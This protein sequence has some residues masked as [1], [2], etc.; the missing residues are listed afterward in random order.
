[1]ELADEA[2]AAAEHSVVCVRACCRIRKF[3]NSDSGFRTSE[4][5]VRVRSADRRPVNNK[6]EQQKRK[7]TRK[8]AVPLH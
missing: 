5:S 8:R 3:G 4:V 7:H 6:T 2:V 1:M